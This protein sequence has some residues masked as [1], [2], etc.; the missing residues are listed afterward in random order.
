M[1]KVLLMVIVLFILIPI[2]SFSQEKPSK[3]I[4]KP[5]IEQISKK[6]ARSKKVPWK[7][8][9]QRENQ[10]TRIKNHNEKKTNI[11]RKR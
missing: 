11:M 3:S 8:R 10:K 4:E 6:R 7:K 9:T 2:Q 1:R 5:N